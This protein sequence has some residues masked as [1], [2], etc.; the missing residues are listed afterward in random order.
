MKLEI[1]V[2]SEISQTQRNKY[3]FS[4]MCNLDFKRHESR[5]GPIWEEEEDQEGWRVTRDENR[6]CIWT[7]YILCIYMHETILY[8]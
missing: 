1:I 7:R 6:G 8:N 2:L 3:V 4:P 5:K